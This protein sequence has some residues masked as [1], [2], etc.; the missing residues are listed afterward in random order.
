MSCRKPEER[1]VILRIWQR[2]LRQTENRLRMR[3]CR[4][5]RVEEGSAVTQS[6]VH[7]AGFGIGGRLCVEGTRVRDSFLSQEEGSSTAVYL[8]EKKQG[9]GWVTA[10]GEQGPCVPDVHRREIE[11]SCEYV[12]LGEGCGW[13][14]WSSPISAS[15]T[16]FWR[17][18]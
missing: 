8:G 2:S 14:S 6:W 18:D 15:K 3:K 4:H 7:A 11:D 16:A 12:E 9:Q 13:G 1:L 17:C 5:A 10:H